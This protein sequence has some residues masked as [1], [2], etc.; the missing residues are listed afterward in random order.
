MATA[1]ATDTATVMKNAE[2]C[3]ATLSRAR[4]DVRGLAFML[5]YT[6]GFSI[7]VAA[8]DWRLTDSV[9]AELTHVDRNGQNESTGT[10]LQMTPRLRLSGRGARVQADIDYGITASTGTG[11]TDPT[12]FSHNLRADGQVE[13][14]ENEFFIGANA[15]ARLVGN[16]ATSGTVD[17]INAESDGRQTFSVEITPEFRHHLNQY[18]DIVSNNSINYV[19]YSGN[20][21]RDDDGSRAI[22][23]NVGVRSGR[24]FGPL[25]WSLDATQNK[26]KF[27]NRDDKRTSYNA[28][29]GYRVDATWRVRGGVGYE[30]NDVLTRRDDTDGAT[31]DAGVDWTPNP[32]TQASFNYGQRYLGNVFSGSFSHRTR[33]TLLSLDASRDV[34][35]R[36]SAQLLDSFFFLVDPNTG[37]PFL[38]PLTGN[39]ILVNIPELEQTDEDFLNTRIRGAVTVTGRRT[40]ATVTATA[41]NRDF[42]VSNVDEDSVGLTFQLTRQLGNGFNV[43]LRSSLTRADGTSSGDSDTQDVQ[44]TLSKQ[45]TPRTSASLNVRRLER[46]GSA[47]NSDYTEN[48]IGIS[49]SS[50]FL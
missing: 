6:A 25:S 4:G 17:A 48:R 31:W 50:S 20:N 40:S 18:A 49:L 44:L 30:K 21:A 27:E 34:S 3:D 32:R 26:T 33:R 46:D 11:G 19:T 41:S 7:T 23:S 12:D 38:D 9:T 13:V 22:E 29:I 45:L 43:S 24:Y 39:P 37:N 15:A 28:T 2:A 14:I 35:N 42:E 16:T 47:A 10:V 5:L 8:G 36:R 1:T